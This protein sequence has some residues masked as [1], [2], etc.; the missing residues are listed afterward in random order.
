MLLHISI[1]QYC[2]KAIS[3]ATLLWEVYRITQYWS[4]LQNAS[5][6]A[7]IL[8]MDCN[9]YFEGQY[10][11]VMDRVNMLIDEYDEPC[12]MASKVADFYLTLP[13]ISVP[14]VYTPPYTLSSC[15]EGKLLTWFQLPFVLGH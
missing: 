10:W 3:S 14:P 8:M 4:V 1:R 6:D 13:A 7:P 5:Q 15:I 2:A 12:F 9:N 11:T